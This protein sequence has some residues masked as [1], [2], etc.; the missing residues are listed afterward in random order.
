MLRIFRR[1]QKAC[2][3]R[4]KGWH[5]R[6]CVCPVWVDGTVDGKPYRESLSTRDWENAEGKARELET[7][8]LTYSP[9]LR[10]IVPAVEAKKAAEASGTAIASTATITIEAAREAFI[11]EA[12]SRML[13]PASIDRYKII[14][15]QL[16]AFAS[17]KGLSLIREI[18]T[19]T[20]QQFRET[21]VGKSGLA[22][23][24]K[25]ERLRQIFKFCVA[26]GYCPT[27]P[28][29]ALAAPV[30]RDAPTMPLEPE[31]I[32]VLL[33]AAET[34]IAEV[35]ANG[36]NRARG[37]KALVLLLRYSGL[38]ISDAVGCA[39]DRLGKDGKLFL[40][41]AKT[42]QHVEVPLPPFVIAELERVPK[43]SAKYWFWSGTS[44]LETARKDWSEA[45]ADLFKA[46]GIQGGHAHRFRDTFAVEFL[47]AGKP[48]ERLSQLLG[49]AN[50]KITQKHY[51]PWDRQR[52]QQVEADVR[53]SWKSDPIVLLETNGVPVR[54]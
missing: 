26:H 49:H 2:P 50:I 37:L 51:N 35:H 47:K 13:K 15:R 24:K 33:T 30:V 11:A 40:H 31:Q 45:L 38:R 12:K 48:M 19:K 5:Y 52:Q 42:G 17:T 29:K 28:A 25:L 10:K 3:H 16:E 1:H 14:F 22:A 8:G 46:A 39:C 41:T 18:D 32:L 6:R 21:W 44:T 43:K 20:L 53:E 4:S 7:S 23:L 34:Y 36:R 54:S 27:N 9:E